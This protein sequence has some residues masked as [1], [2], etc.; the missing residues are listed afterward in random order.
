MQL[1]KRTRKEAKIQQK[2]TSLQNTENARTD[3]LKVF[4]FI[5]NTKLVKDIFIQK[6]NNILKGA[7]I[8]T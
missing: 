4:Q 2:N 3:I 8:G 7:S 1:E 5:K 6:Y